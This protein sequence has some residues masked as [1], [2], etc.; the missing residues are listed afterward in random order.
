MLD[1]PPLPSVDKLL[2]P[3]ASTQVVGLLAELIQGYS[4]LASL[5]RSDVDDLKARLA[6]VEKAQAS[7]G[8]VQAGSV[9]SEPVKLELTP[10][11]GAHRQFLRSVVRNDIEAARRYGALCVF[12]SAI[13]KS[14]PHV[15]P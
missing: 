15:A 10:L 1:S 8:P 14:I 4:C 3:P 6:F 13:L 9:K 2:S 12:L 5:I 11:L 7:P